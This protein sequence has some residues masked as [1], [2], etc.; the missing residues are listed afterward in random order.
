M[1]NLKIINNNI[2]IAIPGNFKYSEH[3]DSRH[4]IRSYSTDYTEDSVQKIVIKGNS[5][6]GPYSTGIESL[7][8]SVISENT[9]YNSD[10]SDSRTKTRAISSAQNSNIENN[11]ITGYWASAIYT[12]KNC[13]ISGNSISGFS[14]Y[15][16]ISNGSIISGN[17]ISRKDDQTILSFITRA[18]DF[19]SS[20]EKVLVVDNVFSHE[21]NDV[22]GKDG[23]LV[24]VGNS[25][26]WIVERNQPNY[27]SITPIINIRTVSSLNELKKLTNIKDG[28]VALL[29]TNIA[30]KVIYNAGLWRFHE[31]AIP[32]DFLTYA[33][34]D[35]AY[36]VKSNDGNGLWHWI[37]GSRLNAP[38]GIAR[39]D[40]DGY[41]EISEQNGAIGR[42][43]IERDGYLNSEGQ[44]NS[45]GDI[46][47]NSGNLYLNEASKTTLNGLLELN[48]RIR[49]KVKYI[50][51]STGESPVIS[52]D[53]DQA[54]EFVLRPKP[55]TKPENGD[56]R[57]ESSLVIKLPRS[58][59]E[60]YVG[61]KIKISMDNIPP[62]YYNEFPYI[63]LLT[64]VY[65]SNG[66]AIIDSN[67]NYDNP[68]LNM[69]SIYIVPW[70]S[71]VMY[72]D[73]LVNIHNK[74]FRWVEYTFIK[75]SEGKYK[76]HLSAYE[77]FIEKG[78][79]AIDN[80]TYIIL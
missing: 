39:L 47:I 73:N 36:S 15:G 22:E 8:N 46:Y 4:A 50:H 38:D 34:E 41:I 67:D 13:N 64:Q 58:D 29:S 53:L 21:T 1:N 42:I 6:H 79:L 57:T 44:I 43:N 72:N 48:S 71:S 66:P 45:T 75:T 55:Q 5:I 80:L 61:S 14:E 12:N 76:Y 69:N 31:D 56:D 40:S 33:F 62:D 52:L 78:R 28:E 63:N 59:P 20:D 60:Y 77:K 19:S 54:D 2:S 37:D 17:I 9:L 10:S 74:I 27:R 16:I 23:D 49:H 51:F 3:N 26:G 32:I 70:V 65:S 18:T 25:P 11:K 68:W 7:Y 30:G 24:K 35:N